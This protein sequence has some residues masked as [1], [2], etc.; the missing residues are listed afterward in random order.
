MATKAL[1]ATRF[2]IEKF[3][4]KNDFSL[5]RVKMRALLVQQ[6]LWKALK[7][8]NALPVTLSKEEKEDLL[9]RAHSAIMLSLRDEVLREIVDEEIAIGLWLKLESQYMTKSL[10]NRLYMKQRLYTI[11]MKEGTP[12]S[13]HLNVFNRIVIDLK[14]IEC[15]VEDEDQALI[16]LCSLPPSFEHF[17]NT[18]LY[19]FGRDSISID[20]VKDALNF[21]ELKKKVSKNWGNNQADGIV[22]RS[23]S[24]ENGSSSNRS[25]SRSGKCHYCKKEGHWKKECTLL[26]EKKENDSTSNTSNIASV[27]EVNFVSDDM[28]LSVSIGCSGDTQVLDS[29]CSYHMIPRRDWFTTYRS[30]SGE[31]LMGNNMTCKV[32][33]IGTVR[34][35]MYDG[36]VRTLSNVRHVPDLRKNLVSLG[37]FDS[38]GYKYT[39][40]GGVLRISK[41]GLVFIKG[42]LGN[43]LYML[44]G[45]TIVGVA[46]ISSSVD[47][48]S[49][50]T[51]LGHMSEV[52]MSILSKQG[53]LHG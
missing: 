14:N 4:K 36:V 43:G 11:R 3:N 37:I 8:K 22:A 17:V 32:L 30:I 23:R 50:N 18:M 5:W 31:V 21:N 19:G 29:A 10:T 13:D 2:E 53:L 25:K 7:G 6:G 48:D 44:Q 42:K 24:N 35:K 51:H 45:S 9:E 49:D 38:Q 40:E 1:S 39:S 26:K 16:L 12:I 41:G 20:D 46:T 52:G 27:A 34:I 28:V 33:G 47:P 15:K